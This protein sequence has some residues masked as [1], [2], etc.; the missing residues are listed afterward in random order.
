MY[1]VDTNVISEARKGRR[2]DPGVRRFFDAPPGELYLPVQVIGELRQGVERIRGRGDEPQAKLLEAW[3][4]RLV[5]EFGHRI[6]T[7]DLDCAQLWGALMGRQA[8]HAID[9]QIAA[10]ALLHDLVVVTRNVDDFAGLG[11]AILDPFEGLLD[12]RIAS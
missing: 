2:G 12:P 9:K 11:V 3:L 6:L 8:Q 7:F 10:I 4:D 5:E 1:L